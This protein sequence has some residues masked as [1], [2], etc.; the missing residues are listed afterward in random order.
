MIWDTIPVA[1]TKRMYTSGWPQ[2]QNRCW[3]SRTF[4]PFAGTKNC[5]PKMRSSSSRLPASVTAGTANTTMNENTSIDH[6]N[7]GSRFSVMPG[8]RILN[9]VTMKL[10]A[11]TVVEMPTNTM[12]SPQKSMLM[13]GLNVLSVSG[14]YPNQ[15][16]S[17]GCP[18]TK[19]EY[20]K[21]PA[22]RKIQ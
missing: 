22:N 14:T 16:P 4:P 2:N 10:I 21:I 6:T 13:P 18:T 8:A 12:P 3:Y 20:M 1:G 9:V 17:G 5:V 7:T 19:L 11:P 15:P